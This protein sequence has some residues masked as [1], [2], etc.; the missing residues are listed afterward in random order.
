MAVPAARVKRRVGAARGVVGAIRGGEG[1]E[2]QMVAAQ[3]RASASRRPVI[4]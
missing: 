1:G 3:G 2:R 4:P